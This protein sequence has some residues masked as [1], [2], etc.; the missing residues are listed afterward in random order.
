[1]PTLQ[2]TDAFLEFLSFAKPTK[3]TAPAPHLSPGGIALRR[4]RAKL[5]QSSSSSA[6]LGASSVARLPL[7]CSIAEKKP[8]FFLPLTESVSRASW[9]GIVLL[10]AAVACAISGDGAGPS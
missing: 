7:E 9:I 6:C 5:D 1:M 3:K 8:L 10:R 4:F 2:T